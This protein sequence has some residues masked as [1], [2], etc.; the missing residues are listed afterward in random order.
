MMTSTP[1]GPFC[2][3]RGTRRCQNTPTNFIPCIQI[4]VS[5]TLSSTWYQ[6][7]TVAY[8][9]TYEPIWN[10]STSLHLDLRISMLSKSRRNFDKRT[11]KTLDLRIHRRSKARETL[12]CKTHDNEK[13]T[14]P[15]HKQR[16]GMKRQRIPRSGANLIKYLGTTLMNVAQRIHWWPRSNLQNQILIL[17]LNPMP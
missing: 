4:W 17:I 12:A 3:K 15:C 1:N 13:K 11:S 8:I 2:V 7:I 6:N 10:S 5:R 9:G 14:S 16:R